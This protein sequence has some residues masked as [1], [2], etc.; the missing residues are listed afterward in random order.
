[1]QVIKK[2]RME[3]IGLL[4]AS[5]PNGLETCST[6]GTNQPGVSRIGSTT[7]LSR[8][9]VCSSLPGS[10]AARGTLQRLCY[11]DRKNIHTGCDV[12]DEAT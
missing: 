1:M 10:D 9:R 7:Q 3:V 8:T 12:N 6:K 4:R 5:V 2:V 11:D